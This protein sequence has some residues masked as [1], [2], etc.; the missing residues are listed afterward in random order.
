[1]AGKSV[2]VLE[3]GGYNNESN[4]TLQEAQATPELY[5]KRGTLTTKDLGVIVLAGRTLGR[6]TTINWMTSLRTPPGVLDEW[7]QRYGMRRHFTGALP[8]QN[9]GSLVE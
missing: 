9:C 4:F 3:K 8:H 6:G 2:I 5:L 1:M 7:G